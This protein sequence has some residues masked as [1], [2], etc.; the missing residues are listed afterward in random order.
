METPPEFDIAADPLLK[1]FESYLVAERNVSENTRA[2]Y[3]VDIA[4]LALFKWGRASC[5]PYAWTAVTEEDARGFLVAFAKEGAAATT[6]HRKLAALRTFYRHL[7]R[8]GVVADNPFAALRGPRA[9]KRLPRVLSVDEVTRFLAQPEADC[10]AGLIGEYG[11]R[12]DRA[13][14]EFLYSTGCRISEALHLRWGRIDLRRGTA[15]VL[16]KGNKERLVILGRPAARALEDLRRQTGESFPL[17]AGDGACVFLSEKGEP[18]CNKIMERRMKRYLA[19]A[20]LPADITPHKLRHSFATHLLDAGA[21]LR[22]VQEM[23]GHA[24]LSTTQVYTH[25]SVERL[26]DEY[27]K[28]HPRA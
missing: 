3:F 19:G 25:V 23:L 15:V 18:M 24:S 27:A 22:S 20:G 16:G 1:G 11:Y 28:A 21:D 14:F 10:R 26:R 13:F 6:S 9:P 2:G 5:P 17:A 8:T 12:R 4:Q 7:Q